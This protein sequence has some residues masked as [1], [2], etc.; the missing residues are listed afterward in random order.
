MNKNV[1]TFTRKQAGKW[2]SVHIQRIKLFFSPVASYSYLL[3]LY[4]HTKW[5]EELHYLV[6]PVQMLTAKTRLATS[7]DLNQPHSVR[8]PYLRMS[9]HSDYIFPRTAT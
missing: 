3:N 6:P 5:S 2:R 1:F 4:F 8:V 7:T 9:F